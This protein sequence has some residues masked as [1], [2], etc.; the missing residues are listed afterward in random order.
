MSE[1]GTSDRIM[2]FQFSDSYR[3]KKKLSEHW[4]SKGV[5][6]VCCKKELTVCGKTNKLLGYLGKDVLHVDKKCSKKVDKACKD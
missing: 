2:I 5:Q 4:S 3:T 6:G 1:V